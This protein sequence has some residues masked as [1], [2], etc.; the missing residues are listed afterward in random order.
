M[1]QL[2]R[3]PAPDASPMAQTPPPPRM[4]L[5]PVGVLAEQLAQCRNMVSGY[6]EY[7]GHGDVSVPEQLEVFNVVTRLIRVSVA[8]AG[9]LDKSP[10]EFTHRV[11]VEHRTS[12]TDVT[13]EL[14]GN[15]PPLIEKSKTIHRGQAPRVHNNE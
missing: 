5:P 2:D 9:A 10:R 4:P 12:L 3:Q 1:E 6:F 7:C 15:P 14:M 13:P 8:L 11:I